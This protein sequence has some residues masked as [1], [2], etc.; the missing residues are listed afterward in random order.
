[1]D[2]LKIPYPVIVEGKYD[3]AK[4]SSVIDARII[5]TDGF[6]IFKNKEKTAL[7]RALAKK[8]PLIVLTDPDGAGGVIRSHICS[9]LPADSVIRLYVPRVKGV[10]KRKKEP[11]AEGVLGVEGM[12]TE[13]LRRIFL[14]YAQD[15]GGRWA[16]NPLCAADLMRDG[17]TGG[18]GSAE[19]RNKLCAV[20]DLP[21]DMNAKALLA[22]LKFMLTYEEYLSAVKKAIGEK[23]K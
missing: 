20:L 4:L 15:D 3:R 5:T 21:P 23:T 10:E 19:R 14:P 2:R 12:D 8:T 1:M 13:H 7:L 9:V 22:A 16:E 17:L 11:S 6:G 18:E